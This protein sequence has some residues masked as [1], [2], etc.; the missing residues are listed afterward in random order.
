MS[1]AT[2]H[3]RLLDIKDEFLR[4]LSAN[5]DRAAAATAVKW[6]QLDTDVRAASLAGLLDNDTVFL[7]HTTASDIS[8][9]S[10][11]SISREPVSTENITAGL[12]DDLE[13][14]F[15]ELTL[16]GTTD[17]TPPLPRSRSSPSP[18]SLPPFIEPAYKWLL[19]HLHNPYP[20]KAIKEKIADETGSSFERIS[21]WFVDVRRRMGWS[22]LLREDFGRKRADL[23]DAATRHFMGTDDKTP[24]PVDIHGKLV[25]MEAFAQDMY[26]A[27]L[28]PSA[29]SNK[30]SAAVKDLTPERRE[31]ARL[32]RLRKL[33]TRRAAAKYPSPA[34]SD[35]PSPVSDYGAL[36]SSA[37]RKRSYSESSDDYDGS[38]S[39]RSRT[40]DG[41]FTLLS[42]P[43]S[44][45]SSP[46]T[47]KRRLSD[48]GAPS[49]KRARTIRAA[50]DPIVVTLSGNPD[51]LADWFSSEL[52]GNTN[53]F[54]P[55]QLLDINSFDP[56]EFD[57]AEESLPAQPV[58][59][60]TKATLPPTSELDTVS[61]DVPANADLEY[62]LNLSNFSDDYGQQISP[63]SDF[64]DLEQAVVSYVPLLDSYSTPLVYEPLPFMEP[65]TGGYD[66]G[67]ITQQ[68]VAESFG[69]DAFSFGNQ[70]QVYSAL[71]NEKA[72]AHLA[73]GLLD[74]QPRKNQNEYTLY[75]SIVC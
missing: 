64:A 34:P 36:T 23:V 26:A 67:F 40:D 27:R 43:S 16:S 32:E 13:N 25:R 63:P 46:T 1:S 35:A 19:K 39:K 20:K 29:L 72:S 38:L 31:Q 66:Q 47:R 60:A 22:R 57:L 55:A 41:A 59:Q 14:L 7:A 9:L 53:I 33:E 52:K 51:D 48:A 24:L 49:A 75:Q 10:N 58:V 61:I 3:Q 5:D 8:I 30:L 71:P 45:H 11:L 70:P 73:A 12:T 21:D 62:W 4:V 50:S 28:V 44:S 68:S 2:I 37:G 6:A 65:L 15:A 18:D 54:D 42:P 74:H 69:L 56:S 17:H